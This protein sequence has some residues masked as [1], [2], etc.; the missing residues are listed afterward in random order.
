MES[1]GF[2]EWAP[3]CARTEPGA[4]KTNIPA[5][6]GKKWSIS[7]EQR[8]KERFAS[9]IRARS[10]NRITRTGAVRKI[11][12]GRVPTRE[13]GVPRSQSAYIAVNSGAWPQLRF[14][15]GNH[16]PDE[17]VWQIWRNYESS[18]LFVRLLTIFESDR[19]R[20]VNSRSRRGELAGSGHG[21]I[22]HHATASVL[23]ALP[24]FFPANAPFEVAVYAVATYTR[25]SSAGEIQR[26]PT[27][28]ACSRFFPVSS[29]R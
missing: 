16:A 5:N 23:Q 9:V 26:T 29:W 4:S 14:V 1:A 17:H 10:S 12:A 21:A 6:A 25:I 2:V 11:G 19:A 20:E 27:S 8:L 13:D 22:D 24:P 7:K 3:S 18:L 15:H 28:L